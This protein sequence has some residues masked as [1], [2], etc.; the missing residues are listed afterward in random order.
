MK[1]LTQ[2]EVKHIERLVRDLI[3][4]AQY[5][6][7]CVIGWDLLDRA[8]TVAEILGLKLDHR[9]NDVENEED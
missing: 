3:Y 1:T 9:G 6:T 4:Q 8:H 7:E 2:A 5:D